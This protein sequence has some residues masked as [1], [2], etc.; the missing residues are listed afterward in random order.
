MAL[1]F[2]PLS[3]SIAPL[4]VL[5]L[6][7][8]T[9]HS[10]VF[11]FPSNF[12]LLFCVL[13]KRHIHIPLSIHTDTDTDTHLH[14]RLSDLLRL[15]LLLLLLHGPS[16]L[17]LSLCRSTVGVSLHHPFVC[18]PHTYF[19]LPPPSSPPIHTYIYCPTPILSRSVAC[20]RL[21]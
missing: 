17:Q 9:V 11:F 4:A 3:G 1:P 12:C 13:K 14:P 18:S 20:L 7:S 2:F 6:I 21:A 19:L 10:T 8:T 5:F 15:L 16:L